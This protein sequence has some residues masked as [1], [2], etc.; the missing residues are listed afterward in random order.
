MWTHRQLNE[1]L[2]SYASLSS[3]IQRSLR[4]RIDPIKTG[5]R[6]KPLFE[7]GLRR[8]LSSRAELGTQ[9]CDVAFRDI[10]SDPIATVEKVY[11][12]FGR[13]VTD[14]HRNAMAEYLKIERSDHRGA[15]QYDA[16]TW[17]LEPEFLN[18]IGTD[19]TM[20]CQDH[21]VS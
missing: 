11:A 15:H 16:S 17:G 21:L 20:V 10:C 9:I 18:S 2:P 4:G 8:G 19:Y 5:Q 3:L 14:L 1:I 6:L 12:H 13:T 7:T